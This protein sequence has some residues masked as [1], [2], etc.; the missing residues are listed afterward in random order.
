MPFLYSL[1]NNNLYYS[2]FCFDHSTSRL[3]KYMNRFN[4]KYSCTKLKLHNIN[5]THKDFIK[6]SILLYNKLIQ[7]INKLYYKEK[8][9]KKRSYLDLTHTHRC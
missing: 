8:L 9:N 3:E 7:T 4:M 2:Q 6:C 5:I 1:L